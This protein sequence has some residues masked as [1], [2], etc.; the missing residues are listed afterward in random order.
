MTCVRWNRWCSSARPSPSVSRSQT[1][2]S[3]FG[4]GMLDSEVGQFNRKPMCATSPPGSCAMREG[5]IPPPVIH[6]GI[7][8]KSTPPP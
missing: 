6:A 1:I 7:G 4:L 2:V 3:L 5:V 8:R